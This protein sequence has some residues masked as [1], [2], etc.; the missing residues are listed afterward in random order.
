[1]NANLQREI[2]AKLM[3]AYVEA[4]PVDDRPALDQSKYCECVAFAFPH[5][6]GAGDCEE[7]GS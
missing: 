7:T 1:M 6:R 5:L 4:V 3:A 2:H